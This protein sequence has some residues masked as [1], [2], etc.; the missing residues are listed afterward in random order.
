MHREPSP[1]ERSG[2]LGYRSADDSAALIGRERTSD[3]WGMEE[4]VAPSESLQGKA[5]DAQLESIADALR[6]DVSALGVRGWSAGVGLGAG[7]VVLAAVGGIEAAGLGLLALVALVTAWRRPYLLGPFAALMLPAGERMH[8]LAAQVA[9]LEAVVGGGA[10]GYLVHLASKRERPR[11]TVAHWVF[12]ALVAAIALSTLGPV[13]DSDRLR[14]VLFWAALGI[15][16]YAVTVQVGS[17]RLLL[18]ALAAATLVEALVTI[19]EYV[20][21]WS[22]R[23][24]LLNGAIV[25]PLPSGTLGHPNALAQFL[26]LAVLGV[27]ALALAEQGA[28]RRVGFL[29]VVMGSLAL[30]VTFSRASWIAFAVGVSVYLLDRRTRVP[31]LAAGA[32]AAIGAAS[33]ALFNA[34]AIGARI[35]S[36]F[37]GDTAGLYGFRAELVRRAAETIADHPFAGSGRFEEAG[38]YA[39]RPDLATHPHNLFLGVAVFFGIPAAIAF[40]ALVLLALRSAWRGSRA[41]ASADSLTALGFLALLVALL[42]NGILEYPLW[43]TSLLV[44]VV[45]AL[46]VA[47]TLGRDAANGSSASTETT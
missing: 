41:R 23:F 29:A 26:V 45:L 8:V 16:F 34:G 10:V 1:T 39:G 19:Y 9:P 21:G 5:I 18:V 12:A 3:K 33:L 32:V 46:A 25:Y 7:I 28:L 2:A 47:I 37:S 17:R 20:D 31:V 22:D 6:S 4:P 14:E 40:G 36:P 24:S 30:V 42:V 13:D 38:V 27:L 44:L 35:S 15:V 43:N 11:L